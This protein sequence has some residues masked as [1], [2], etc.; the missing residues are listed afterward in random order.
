MISL[1]FYERILTA[2]IMAR[3]GVDKAFLFL[4]FPLLYHGNT[5]LDMLLHAWGVNDD[6]KTPSTEINGT[7]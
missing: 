7:K 6:A 1:A 4:L 2:F 5:Y 3:G